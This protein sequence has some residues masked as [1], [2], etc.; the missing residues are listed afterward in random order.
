MLHGAPLLFLQRAQ[1]NA[2]ALVLD[3]NGASMRRQ[4]AAALTAPPGGAPLADTGPLAW[5]GPCPPA[6]LHGRALPPREAVI[7]PF[8]A[9]VRALGTA[10]ALADE[11]YSPGGTRDIDMRWGEGR[12]SVPVG[13]SWRGKFSRAAVFTK[14]PCLSSLWCQLAPMYVNRTRILWVFST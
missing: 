5:L 8:A 1:G 13:W 2:T 14:P 10:R 12:P 9:M 6:K 4:R 11:Y 7:R 3:L